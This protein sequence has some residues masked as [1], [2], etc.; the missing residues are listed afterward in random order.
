MP[1]N[2][3]RG[4]HGVL[5]SRVARDGDP[6]LDVQR[7]GRVERRGRAA[8]GELLAVEGAHPEVDEHAVAE[9]LPLLQAFHGKPL[10]A[11]PSLFGDGSGC[12][13]GTS[14]GNRHRRGEAAANPF[15]PGQLSRSHA[16]TS[17]GQPAE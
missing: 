10:R 8:V 1:R 6:L 13:H 3:L 2:V 4:E 12:R 7:I 15:T 9:G 11:P 16:T 14:P 5:H 17:G